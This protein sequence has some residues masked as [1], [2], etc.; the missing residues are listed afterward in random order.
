M[1]LLPSDLLPAYR[2][3]VAETLAD[4]HQVRTGRFGNAKLFSRWYNDI[5]TGKHMVVVVVRDLA[6]SERHW[7]I[8]AYLARRLAE[9][10]VRWTQH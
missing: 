5:R 6:P 2:D 9:G 1:S 7:I 4:P 8:T 10:D 3:R